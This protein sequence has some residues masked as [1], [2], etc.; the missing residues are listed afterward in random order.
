MCNLKRKYAILFIFYHAYEIL[1]GNILSERFDG[2]KLILTEEQW[3]KKLT[4]EQF[5]ILREGKTE[6]AFQNAYFAHKQKGTYVCA[7]CGLA[8]YESAAKY[9][10][11]TGW[12]S[13]WAPIFPENVSYQD[14]FHL[15][16]K[17]TEVL[18]SRCHGHL[19]HVFS[20][21]PLP[22]GRRYCMNSAALQ[23]VAD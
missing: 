16:L 4:K 9:D 10:S 13:F 5:R 22:T 19:G 7:G 20:D 14:D 1:K 11:G 6:P 23:F 12:P 2:K 8:L 3:E 18:C 15:S 21:G 17:R